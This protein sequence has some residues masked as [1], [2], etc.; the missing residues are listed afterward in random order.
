MAPCPALAWWALANKRGG[1]SATIIK[2][3]VILSG[4]EISPRAASCHE[5]LR[6]RL[7]NLDRALQL[8]IPGK[9]DLQGAD[10]NTKVGWGIWHNPCANFKAERQNKCHTLFV[11]QSIRACWSQITPEIQKFSLF[12]WFWIP[13]VAVAWPVSTDCVAPSWHS[14]YHSSQLFLTKLV[15]HG[16]CFWPNLFCMATV[17]F[18]A[19]LFCTATTVVVDRHS[20][21]LFLIK[22]HVLQR[23]DS[24]CL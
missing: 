20:S 1:P 11:N 12:Q 14:G 7:P 10:G 8:T 2:P 17:L 4:W 13:G 9:Y 19:E 24:T 22:F 21:Q 6:P 3:S 16:Y 5:P 15:L 18:L 23:S